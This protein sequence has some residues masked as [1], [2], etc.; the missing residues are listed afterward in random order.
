[1]NDNEMTVQ[2][3]DGETSGRYVIKLS[4]TAEA[5]MTYRKTE[6][7]IIIDHTG[8]PPSFEGRGIAAKLV[9][10]AVADA[11]KNRFRITPVCSYVVAQFRRH[12][13]WSDIKA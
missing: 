12:P 3:E 10:F 9:E 2:R 11:R 4:P 5:E 6:S 13:K 1:M 8:V 7:G